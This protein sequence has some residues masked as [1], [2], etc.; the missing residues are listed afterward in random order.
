M[1]LNISEAR[2]LVLDLGQP[3]QTI[4]WTDFLLSYA[5][6]TAALVAA[7][8]HPLSSGIFW[9][10][11]T[12]SL[13][14]FYRA[15]SFIHELAHFKQRLKSFRILWNALAGVPMAFPAFMYTRSHSVHH[16]PNTYGTDADGEYVSFQNRSR[17]QI[18]AYL[19]SSFISVPA[20]VFRF[21]FLYP[22]SLV[23]PAV[24]KFVVE[25]GSSIVIA[26]DYVG[27][28]PSESEKQ[29]WRI[30]ETA[31]CLFWLTVLG[32][33][34]AGVIPWR[35]LG[36]TYLVMSGALFLNNMRTLAAH[37][38]ANDGRILTIEEQLLDS[39]NLVNTFPGWIF[40][41][42]A[43]PVGLRYHALHHL[44]PFL[45]Y[46]ALGTAHKRLAEKLPHDSSYHS[47]SE[48]GVFV[49]VAKLWRHEAVHS[50]SPAEVV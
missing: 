4:Y 18:F 39:V 12:V 13:L 44:F 48:A 5:L 40:S 28:W 27:H 9:A 16:N 21:A 43:A 11:V 24:R 37:R 29:E 7:Y 36:V 30:M 25:R 33:A 49:A 31:C 6:G 20:L 22:I 42:L 50:K 17:W 1:A 45:P 41:A 32:A 23:S 34:S 10:W 35:V 47:V 15:L 3:N 19:A 14:A 8:P 46:H 2:K 26:I 38:F